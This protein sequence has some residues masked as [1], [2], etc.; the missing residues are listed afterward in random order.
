MKRWMWWAIA[1]LVPGG[2]VVAL[3][4]RARA[5]AAP[6]VAPNDQSE[7]HKQQ[8]A[9]L[10]ETAVQDAASLQSALKDNPLAAKLL[11]VDYSLLDATPASVAKNQARIDELKAVIVNRQDDIR[12]ESAR[13]ADPSDHNGGQSPGEFQARMNSLNAAIAAAQAELSTL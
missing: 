13:Y 1:L 2:L 11:G 9:S 7:S 8:L 5:A 12:K 6:V 4:L 10:T 3:V